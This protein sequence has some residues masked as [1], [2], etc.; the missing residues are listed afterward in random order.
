ME[1]VTAAPADTPR[2]GAF[3]A[4]K[5][6]P[7]P[8]RRLV[9]AVAVAAARVF[10][11]RRGAAGALRWPIPDAC[12]HTAG[13]WGWGRT[14]SEGL[15][16]LRAQARVPILPYFRPSD[17]TPTPP[18]GRAQTHCALAC[19][20]LSPLEHTTSVGWQRQL[21]E[22]VS[23]PQARAAPAAAV[24]RTR[25]PHRAFTTIVRRCAL[26]LPISHG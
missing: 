6:P 8:L 11:L 14:S 1:A 18:H 10:A 4:T 24:E 2:S 5:S 13:P 9:V 3:F 22:P 17:T 20:K 15:A 26:L 12:C 16:R 7:L 21:S 23:L 25:P 19:L